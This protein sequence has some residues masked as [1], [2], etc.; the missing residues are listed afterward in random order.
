PKPTPVHV[1]YSSAP[2]ASVDLPTVPASLPPAPHLRGSGWTLIAC[3][4]VGLGL[5]FT[6]LSRWAHVAR[7]IRS[8][9]DASETLNEILDEV[10][11]AV[12]FKARVQIRLTSDTISPAVCGLWSPV[13]LLPRVL[14]E[15]LTHAELRG[16]LLHELMH[17]KRR[18][19]WVN[20]AQILL[21][22]I[23]WW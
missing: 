5:F 1:T 9:T 3:A 17:L 15:Q 6:V 7:R 18:D 8:T 4:A 13:I 16:V 22:L 2:L 11:C 21:Q 10:R 12:R 14:A 23:Y 20:C 19:I